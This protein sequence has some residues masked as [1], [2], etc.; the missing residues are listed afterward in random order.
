MSKKSD[1]KKARRRKRLAA[2]NEAWIPAPI[3][4]ELVDTD[5]TADAI[6]EAIAD[7]DEWISARGWELDRDNTEDLVSWVYPP[8][9]ASFDD[10]S[11]EPV[12]RVW[13]T[14]TEDDDAVVLEFGA[15]LV[16]DG[17][18]D[19]PYLV[20]PDTLENDIAELEAYRPGSPR[21]ELV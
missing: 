14:V 2:R 1:A 7:I 20:D 13:I 3:F 5:D 16:G 15:L 12:T 9:A 21:P 10:G 4:D 11:R 17:A 6:G 18:D 19:E 8:S